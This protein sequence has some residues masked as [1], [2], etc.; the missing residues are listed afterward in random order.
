MTR[1]KAR[2]GRG[3]SADGARKE[4]IKPGKERAYVHK[5][6]NFGRISIFP[7]LL[8]HCTAIWSF[9]SLDDV[10]AKS[11]TISSGNFDAGNETRN[12]ILDLTL[13]KL[14]P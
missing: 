10:H 4:R 5:Y 11:S 14:L 9:H 1:F 13:G 6:E 7:L 12:F 8:S 3:K 2:I